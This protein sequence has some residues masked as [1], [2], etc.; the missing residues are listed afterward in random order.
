MSYDLKK[1]EHFLEENCVKIV[2]ISEHSRAGLVKVSA[3]L[4]PITSHELQYLPKKN[5]FVVKNN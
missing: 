2:E 3:K 5:K 4:K 1:A